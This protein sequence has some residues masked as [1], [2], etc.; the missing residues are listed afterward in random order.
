GAWISMQLL[1]RRPEIDGFI[2][3]APPANMYDFTFLAPCPSSGLIIQGERDTMVPT[4][5]TEKLVAKLRSQKGITI[6]YE[7]VPGADHFFSQHV[8]HL[9]ALSSLYLD[10]NMKDKVIEP[11]SDDEEEENDLPMLEDGE[12]EDAE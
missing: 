4:A 7:V 2:V 6:D 12:M 11:P 8:E 10:A 9:V 5:A 1:M 3:V